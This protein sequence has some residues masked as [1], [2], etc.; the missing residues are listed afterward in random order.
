M[1]ENVATPPDASPGNGGRLRLAVPLNPGTRDRVVEDHRLVLPRRSY[2]LR[3]PKRRRDET[4]YDAATR[5]LL[6]K[7]VAGLLG[8]KP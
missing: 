1:G 5:K 8:R 7:V 4:E 6:R 2:G 3:V